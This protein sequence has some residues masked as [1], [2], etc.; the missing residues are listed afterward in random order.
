M[1]ELVDEERALRAR[2]DQRHLALEDVP[3]L[4]QLV[5]GRSTQEPAE[6]GHPR[7]ALLRPHRA[8]LR[9]RVGAHGA[10]LQHGED[11]PVE[12]HTILPEEDRRAVA[13]SDLRGDRDE[14]WEQRD[15]HRARADQV[16]RPL[17][18]RMGAAGA[19]A[20]QV[21]QREPL[22]VGDF[23]RQSVQPLQV[24]D[25]TETDRRPTQRAVEIGEDAEVAE[26]HRDEDLLELFLL[27]EFF[28]IVDRAEDAIQR[29]ARPDL[30]VRLRVDG[31]GRVARRL[32]L[33][34][35]RIPPA[36]RRRQVRV[37]EPNHAEPRP[38]VRAESLVEFAREGA[39]PDDRAT[40][41]AEPALVAPA[42]RGHP[43][44]VV[45]EHA[46]GV[47]GEESGDDHARVT[48]PAHVES[49]G[50][51]DQRRLA[52]HLQ[53]VDEKGAVAPRAPRAI[54]PEEEREGE[55]DRENERQR[56]Q[57]RLQRRQLFRN[58]EDPDLRQPPRDEQ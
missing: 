45:E 18:E 23:T 25:P 48:E 53:N 55:K 1:T 8:R 52:V 34:H 28:E 16:E 51:E 38:R 10:E 21:D 19:Y 56:L 14:H 6:L 54:E 22:Q 36:R 15:Q 7:V 37:D 24:G 9:L 49:D 20:A 47:Q 27:R 43:E 5:E 12:S 30:F 35:G 26:V 3:K 39:E 29:D 41:G 31:T 46:A 32:R 33:V 13:Q 11:A 44:E 58:R 4:R 42:F 57:V 2:A 40:A 50:E 17:H